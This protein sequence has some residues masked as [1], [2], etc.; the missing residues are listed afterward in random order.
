[1]FLR[2]L[3]LDDAGSDA[4]LA[5]DDL[6]V[7]F[8]SVPFAP[9]APVIVS[10]NTVKNDGAANNPIGVRF[11]QT[12]DDVSAADPANY[13]VNAGAVTVVAALPRP[14][15][16]SVELKLASAVGEFFSVCATNIHGTASGAA[17]TIA[18]GFPSEYSGATI[19]VPGDP[20]TP[21]QIYSDF[22]DSHVVTASG[23]GI[24]G[25][26]DRFHFV[27]QE[28]A[29]DF[30][31]RVLVTHLGF[32]DSLSQAGLMARESLDPSSASLQ[33]YFTPTQ[34]V[35]QIDATV[36]PFVGVATTSFLINPPVSATPLRWLRI[37][38]S[39]DVFTTYEGTNGVT[40][41]VSGAITQSFKT[42]LLV[43]MAAC[44]HNSG[45]NNTASF[46][47]FSA[48]GGRPGDDIRPVLSAGLSGS[49]VVLEWPATP[50]SY[51]VEIATDLSTSNQWGLLSV[52]Y[53]YNLSNRTFELR[54][55]AGLMGEKLFLRNT[56]VDKLI[57]DIPAIMATAGIIL[58]P[59]A[60]LAA[61]TSSTLCS[62]TV[63]NAYTQTNSYVAFTNATTASAIDSLQSSSSM[64]TVLQVRNVTTNVL[65]PFTCN[66]D[67]YSLET[68]SRVLPLPGTSYPAFTK[69]TF[70]VGVK[71]TSTPKSTMKVYITP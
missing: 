8:D 55:P 50:R 10:L 3:K 31:A 70:V 32:A 61:S 12:V 49:D 13:V 52:P 29:G 2:W 48:E 21:G 7:S 45:L 56:R 39:G 54:L 37:T 38:R 66:D 65:G 58:S 18:T 41:N 19:G 35:N 28:M 57:P 44:S 60:G 51:A 63:T 69:F 11:D 53:G 33:T 17:P 36:R 15:G 6:T 34:G 64:N 23:S 62:S 68:R 4:G 16:R 26:D 22:W 30:D 14:D 9:P 24:G 46:T 25:S 42:N 67:A 5:V 43:G 27:Y 1:L 40:W 59:G 47:D 71:T 20:A